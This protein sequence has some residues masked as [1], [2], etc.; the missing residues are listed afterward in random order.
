MRPLHIRLTEYEKAR[1]RIFNQPKRKIRSSKRIQ[2]YYRKLRAYRRCVISPITTKDTDSR[3]YVKLQVLDSYYL[4]LLDSGANKSVI[5]ER[6]AIQVLSDKNFRKC[7]GSVRT[8]D[9]QRQNVLGTVSLDVTFDGQTK[10]FEFLVV[11]TTG[12]DLWL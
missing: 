9:G 4:A 2:E 12:L 10:S 5:G 3:P 6:L 8:A 1:A 7:C 11:P